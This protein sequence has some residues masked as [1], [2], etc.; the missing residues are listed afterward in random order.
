MFATQIN[1]VYCIH[2]LYVYKWYEFLMIFLVLVDIIILL[3]RST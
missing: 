2:A 1:L 3:S